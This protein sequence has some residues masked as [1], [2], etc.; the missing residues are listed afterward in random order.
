M[1]GQLGKYVKKALGV[2]NP[3]APRSTDPTAHSEGV[4]GVDS[5]VSLNSEHW[6]LVAKNFREAI[7]RLKS[8]IGFY[9]TVVFSGKTEQRPKNQYGVPDQTGQNLQPD[10]LNQLNQESNQKPSSD[11]GT[12]QGGSKMTRRQF[13]RFTGTGVGLILAGYFCRMPLAGLLDELVFPPE[14]LVKISLSELLQSTLNSTPRA[15]GRPVGK[16]PENFARNFALQSE[17]QELKLTIFTNPLFP[18]EYILVNPQKT[19]SGVYLERSTNVRQQSQLAQDLNE[20]DDLGNLTNPFV[21]GEHLKIAGFDIITDAR[22]LWDGQ[23]EYCAIFVDQQNNYLAIGYEGGLYGYD[24]KLKEWR[25]L[26][27]S[28]GNYLQV[29]AEWRGLNITPPKMSE[30]V[31]SGLVLAKQLGYSRYP[32]VRGDVQMPEMNEKGGKFT[33]EHFYSKEN[34][35][36]RYLFG[37]SGEIIDLVHAGGMAEKLVLAVIQ[38]LE[39]YNK[40]I[41]ASPGLNEVFLE[42]SIPHFE[43]DENFPF[44]YQCKLN[45]KGLSEAAATRAILLIGFLLIQATGFLMETISQRAVRDMVSIPIPLVVGM[46]PEDMYSNSLGMWLALIELLENEPEEITKLE[47]NEDREVFLK[48][49]KDKI[50]DQFAGETPTEEVR[51]QTLGMYPFIPVVDPVAFRAQ[52]GQ[53]T[54]PF[55]SGDQGNFQTIL[56]DLKKLLQKVTIQATSVPYLAYNV[57]RADNGIR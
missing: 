44:E 32:I 19:F 37:K 41:K 8:R 18:D 34:P 38:M 6:V 49:I 24:P 3:E 10:N 26:V 11:R 55:L 2:E 22:G 50:I 4:E 7:E 9:F 56:A 39:Q 54:N 33:P 45:V 40:Q 5:S 15:I 51:L 36:G 16:I 17:V 20:E 23:Q 57:K 52:G 46:T 43:G 25:R 53:I 13:L 27:D 30:Q 14:K 35:Y 31:I 42:V 47:N 48:R 29:E 21:L 28:D 12:N 1:F